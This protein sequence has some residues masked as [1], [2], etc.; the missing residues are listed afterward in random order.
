MMKCLIKERLYTLR[1]I[2]P[3]HI[4]ITGATSGIRQD[5]H[6]LIKNAFSDFR[7]Q[8]SLYF[9]RMSESL[10]KYISRGYHLDVKDQNVMVK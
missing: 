2:K 6:A 8:K 1:R 4:V 3:K 7:K 5:L 10:L 9:W